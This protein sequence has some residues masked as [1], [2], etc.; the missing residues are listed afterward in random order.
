MPSLDVTQTSSVIRTTCEIPGKLLNAGIFSIRLVFFEKK[1]IKII[2]D[3]KD[4][5]QFE[6]IDNKPRDI[7]WH[8]KF[9]GFFHP[10]LSW[11]SEI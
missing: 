3:F 9:K 10:E 2:S 7:M 8:G 5:A 1:D 6:I 4:I 11:K